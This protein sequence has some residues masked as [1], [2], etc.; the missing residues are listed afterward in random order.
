MNGHICVKN[1]LMMN[2]CVYSQKVVPHLHYPQR[3]QIGRFFKVYGDK[4]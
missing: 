4:F 3:D 1:A 2:N